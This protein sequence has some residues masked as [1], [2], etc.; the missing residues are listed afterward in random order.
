[1]RKAPDGDNQ[2]G[3][4]YE[5]LAKYGPCQMGMHVSYHISLMMAY[6]LKEIDICNA[7]QTSGLNNLYIQ[8][9]ASTIAFSL[10]LHERCQ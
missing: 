6:I 10:R 8:I 2:Q 5:G 9:F 7:N 4:R 1:M 3:G